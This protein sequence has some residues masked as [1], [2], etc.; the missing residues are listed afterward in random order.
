MVTD[1]KDFADMFG[2][3]LGEGQTVKLV[4]PNDC[5]SFVIRTAVNSGTGISGLMVG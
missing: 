1:T 4:V 5:V 3:A 2:Q